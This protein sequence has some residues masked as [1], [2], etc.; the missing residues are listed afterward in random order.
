MV[1]VE[2]FFF[3][4]CSQFETSHKAAVSLQALCLAIQLMKDRLTH[5]YLAHNKLAGIPQIVTALAV[6]FHFLIQAVKYLNS[7]F[8]LADFLSE[9]AVARPVQ[10]NY[11]GQFARCVAFGKAADGL[12]EIESAAHHEFA[13]HARCGNA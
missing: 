9:S 6:G 2:C 12:S 10:R 3:S 8:F 1:I 11:G 5:L 7:F 4:C 13:H